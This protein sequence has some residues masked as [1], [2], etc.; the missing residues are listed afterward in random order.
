MIAQF[1]GA[2]SKLYPQ[3]KKLTRVINHHIAVGH[4]DGSG[5]FRAVRKHG[6]AI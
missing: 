5:K 4:H 1:A 2:C 6:A 3:F